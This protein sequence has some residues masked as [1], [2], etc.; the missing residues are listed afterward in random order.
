M[1]TMPAHQAL[2]SNFT[3][4]YPMNVAHEGIVAAQVAYSGFEVWLDCTRNAAY[5]FE[6]FAYKDCGKL[7]RHAGFRR[8]PTFPS[9]CQ[10]RNGK[11]YPKTEGV[12]FD[13]GHMVPANH[14]DGDALAIMQSNYM[15]N[16]LPQA[17]YMNRGAWL[18]TEEIIECW[19][20]KEALHVL[21]GAIFDD[22]S[23]RHAWFKESHGVENPTLFWKI[24]TAQSLF[25]EDHHRIAWIIPNLE[26][27]KRAT[28]NKYIVSIAE[29]EAVLAKGGQAQTFD[30]TETERQH[31]P[32]IS[33][34][35]PAGCDKSL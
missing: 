32:K 12:S 13:R 9:N 10:Q 17:A 31:K 11:A 7:P 22:T 21:G 34:K 25:K 23:K 5:R 8:D 15:T 33:W 19:R 20:E 16:I 29:L 14:L 18:Q 35:L 26:T 30:V 24:V 3:S 1:K 2:T 28:L 4:P 6:Y 27:A